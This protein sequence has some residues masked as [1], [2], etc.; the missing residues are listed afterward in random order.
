MRL[1]KLV[2]LAT[3]VIEYEKTGLLHYLFI[4]LHISL[5]EDVTVF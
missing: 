1:T 2:C 5:L 4:L 3:P